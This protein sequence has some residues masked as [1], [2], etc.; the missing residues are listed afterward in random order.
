MLL[1]SAMQCGVD[2]IAIHPAD[3]LE[4]NFFG[5]NRFAFAMVRATS[6]NFMRHSSDHIRGSLIALRLPLRK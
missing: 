6:E 1:A 4:G 2:E 5:A 3:E